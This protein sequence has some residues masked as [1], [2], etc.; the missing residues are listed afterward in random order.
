M[1][2]KF[3]YRIYEQTPGSQRKLIGKYDSWWNAAWKLFCLN[4]KI[5]PFRYAYHI[6]RRSYGR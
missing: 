4:I 2:N 1:N 5:T 6:E 3:E